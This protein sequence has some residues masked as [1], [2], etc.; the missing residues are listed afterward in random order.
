VLVTTDKNPPVLVV[1]DC[2]REDGTVCRWLYDRTDQEWL[3]R[4]RT[5]CSP[6]RR[7]SC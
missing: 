2:I 3:A 6:S 7:R 5:G 1:Q 4:R